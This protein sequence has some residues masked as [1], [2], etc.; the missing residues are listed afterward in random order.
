MSAV[1]QAK[2]VKTVIFYSPSQNIM[3]KA[4]LILL[5]IGAFSFQISV[6]AQGKNKR[7]AEKVTAANTTPKTDPD[8]IPADEAEK[9]IQPF[10]DY[11]DA[12]MQQMTDTYYYSAGAD[13]LRESF[14]SAGVVD[15]LPLANSWGTN[16]V[17]LTWSQGAKRFYIYHHNALT[18]SI[19]II[20]TQGYATQA[21]LDY[22]SSGMRKWESYEEHFPQIFEGY[23]DNLTQQAV[24]LD[25]K[26]ALSKEYD[27]RRAKLDGMRPYPS[28][29]IKQLSDAFNAAIKEIDDK[30][31]PI[32]KEESLVGEEVL[33]HAE[34]HL[35]SSIKEG[36]VTSIID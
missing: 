28:G 6:P 16:G 30:M 34:K 21:D 26:S 4:S 32:L 23:I 31:A 18:D 35:F 19:A 11:I 20:R 13:T 17:G 8:K 15:S 3:A 33:K 24:W 14:Q 7:P 12:R 22:L 25:K 2:E 29:Q 1:M 5:A 9:Q 10:V 27:A 36:A